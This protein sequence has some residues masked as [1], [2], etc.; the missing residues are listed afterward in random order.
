M[1]IFFIFLFNP[2][3]V[4]CPDRFLADRGWLGRVVKVIYGVRGSFVGVRRVV[5]IA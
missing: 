1:A 3:G 2:L 5:F 4:M